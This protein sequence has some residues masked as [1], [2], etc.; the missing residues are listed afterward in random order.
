MTHSSETGTLSIASGT[1]VGAI[2]STVVGNLGVAAGGTAFA[3]GALPIMG[4]GALVGAAAHGLMTGIAQGDSTA[5]AATGIGVASGLGVSQAIGGI[6]IVGKFGAISVGA[7]SMAVMGGVVGLGLYGVAKLLDSGV[8]ESPAQVF[9]RM[10]DK[11]AWQEAYNAALIELTLGSLFKE[12]ELKRRFFIELEADE[13]IRQLKAE[14]ER[15][16]RWQPKPSLV[17]SLTAADFPQPN[18]VWLRVES[19]EHHAGA[20]NAI[21]VNQSGQTIATGGDD[22]T[23]VLWDFLTG[24]RLYTFCLN[25]AV[26]TIAISVNDQTIASGGL[27]QVVT[28]W[29][30][31][32]KCLS[33]NPQNHAGIVYSV[34]CSADNSILASGSADKT[35]RL[36][37]R[38]TGILK[39][40]LTGHTDSVFSIAIS[41]DNQTL[42]SGGADCTVRI[43]NLASWEQ[44][45]ILTG[46][47][48]WVNAVSISSDGQTVISASVDSTLRLW[49]LKTGRLYATL[50]AHSSAV[51]AIAVNC[52]GQIA[53]SSHDGVI[54]LWNLI[55]TSE[56]HLDAELLCTLP[57]SACSV[58]FTP[59]GKKLIA[60]HQ[61]GTISIW[62]AFRSVGLQS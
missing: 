18:D 6:G 50:I 48:G 34:V 61:D 42:V 47:T 12:E 31:E 55:R 40:T 38:T 45:K 28:R 15:Q 46:H 56:G 3:V 2:T 10:E 16:K 57:G 23:V 11:I 5:Y 30:L 24:R 58:A 21:A 54:K 37:H 44:P 1:A 62:Q 14:I 25:A 39:R 43:W 59:D 17:N 41:P 19:L 51:V 60:G 53:S 36:W 20:V 26:R 29:Q 13:E 27:D 52:N 4:A 32:T 35:I 33:G 7:G 9:S 8:K 49:D 22:R